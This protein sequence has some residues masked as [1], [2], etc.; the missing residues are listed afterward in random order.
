L[1]RLDRIS[2]FRLL[3]LLG[4]LADNGIAETV[5]LR[6]DVENEGIVI[7]LPR[8]TFRVIYKHPDEAVELV[9]FAVHADKS[10]GISQSDFLARAWRVANDKARELA[11][12]D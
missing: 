9:A 8:T 3:G 4:A 1:Q 6:V 7:T 2:T 5:R 10:A 12:I 11:W